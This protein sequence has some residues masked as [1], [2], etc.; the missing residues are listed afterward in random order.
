[1]TSHNI[2]NSPKSYIGQ[3]NSAFKC[4]LKK[5]YV[6]HYIKYITIVFLFKKNPN[7]LAIDID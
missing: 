3:I 1:M 2:P 7:D 4:T 5:K 6:P